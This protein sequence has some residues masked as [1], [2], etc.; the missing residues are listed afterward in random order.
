MVI[1]MVKARTASMLLGGA[2]LVACGVLMILNDNLDDILWL[3]IMM[4]VGLF[5]TG[6]FEYLGLRAPLKDERVARIGT[7]AMTYSW[8]S[9]LIVVIFIALVYGMGG[10]HKIGMQQAVGSI[11]IVMVIST[12]G[13]NW[14]V[15][16][17]GDVE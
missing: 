1:S 8:Y 15:G 7:L 4:G 12:F 9:V 5:G 2:L 17:K 3:E 14:Y 16:R 10:G 11:L 13:F 6:L